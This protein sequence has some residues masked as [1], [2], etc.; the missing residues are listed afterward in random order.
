MLTFQDLFEVRGAL[1]IG[2]MVDNVQRG[3]ALGVLDGRISTA[4]GNNAQSKRSATTQGT[5]SPPPFSNQQHT[6]NA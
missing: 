5:L 3:Q 2:V 1:R 6:T 4:L